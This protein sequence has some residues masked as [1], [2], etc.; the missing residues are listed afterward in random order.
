MIKLKRI[1]GRLSIRQNA[2]PGFRC[3]RDPGALIFS[4]SLLSHDT[5]LR[6][7]F[8][9]SK[10][11][12]HWPQARKRDPAPRAVY[13]SHIALMDPAAARGYQACRQ[14][15]PYV[16]QYP[17]AICSGHYV[18]RE[19]RQPRSECVVDGF[20]PTIP[21]QRPPDIQHDLDRPPAP[22]SR[23]SPRSAASPTRSRYSPA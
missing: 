13:R 20:P 17:S 21:A 2:V 15:K 3:K 22:A 7:Y 18:W 12:W 5:S 16:P 8:S 11:R 23:A 6:M 19:P 10:S 14:A 1:R 4:T 9:L